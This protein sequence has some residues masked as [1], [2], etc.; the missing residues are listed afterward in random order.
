LDNWYR[1]VF[2]PRYFADHLTD[3]FPTWE[4]E[5]RD[6]RLLVLADTTI[7]LMAPARHLEGWDQF[8]VGRFLNRFGQ[9]WHSLAW[10]VDDID[11]LYHRLREAG[12]RCFIPG[13]GPLADG[14]GPLPGDPVFTHPRDTICALE[15]MRGPTP[16]DPR[17]LPGWDGRWWARHHPLGVVGLSH[18]TLAVKDLDQ[19]ERIYA[20]AL[21]G[22]PLGS[23]TSSLT[24]TRGSLVRIG[25]DTILELAVPIASGALL[26]RD[27]DRFGEIMHS[28]TW[29]VEDLD[30][31]ASYLTATGVS[32]LARDESTLICDPAKTFGAVFIFTTEAS[33]AAD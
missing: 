33:P 22:T 11:G 25:A 15:F 21:E 28:T 8:P 27:L 20:V 2:G 26:A 4:V 19:A 9:H 23:R 18:I 30:A 6:A 17:Y 31:A 7:E 16:E 3:V 32:V 10:Y 5:K 13:R 24:Q 12:V 1:D 29:T 14:Q